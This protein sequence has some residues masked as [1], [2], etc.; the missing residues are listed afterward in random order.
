MSDQIGLFVDQGV[1]FGFYSQC[2]EKSL[3]GCKQNII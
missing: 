1:E 3:M 2:S